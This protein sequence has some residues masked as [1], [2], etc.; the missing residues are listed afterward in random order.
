L[1]TAKNDVQLIIL[2]DRPSFSSSQIAE[3]TDNIFSKL[4]S[5]LFSD[6]YRQQ[7][8]SFVLSIL[9]IVFSRAAYVTETLLPVL[10]YSAI[11]VQF[12]S[13]MKR[14]LW[15]LQ[16]ANRDAKT[17]VKIG[18]LLFSMLLDV[19]LG[20]IC[21]NLVLSL[22]STEEFPDQFQWTADKCVMSLRNLLNWLRGSPAGFKLNIKFNS[23]LA[24]FYLFHTEIWWLFLSKYPRRVSLVYDT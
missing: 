14:I 2:F 17:N 5:K 13:A 21:L 20:W 11:G 16:S 19:C 23:L 8:A 22:T 4:Q 12:N 7:C 3:S 10:K 18:N 6:T 15:V 9:L 1:L 24:Q